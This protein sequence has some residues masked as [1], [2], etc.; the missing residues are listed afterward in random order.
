M[1]TEAEL[2]IAIHKGIRQAN[3]NIDKW[4]GGCY[5][6][7]DAAAEGFMVTHIARAIKM[8]HN[9]PP[10]FLLVEPLVKKLKEDSGRS[11]YLGRPIAA[12]NKL[13]R[14]D[15]AILNNA[16]QLKYVI[17]AK[18]SAWSDYACTRDLTRLI[19][20]QNDFSKKYKETAMQ[21]GIFAMFVHSYSKNGI[22]DAK[23]NLKDK[24]ADWENRI[25]N[26]ISENYQN[27]GNN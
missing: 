22:K 5:F 13:K 23:K 24:L 6:L 25:N 19:K 12:L 18:C 3:N 2:L 9:N 11:Q 27:N 26:F 14:V 4:S 15:L 21:A 1:M 7:T 17:E 20:M 8:Y 10:P 16:W